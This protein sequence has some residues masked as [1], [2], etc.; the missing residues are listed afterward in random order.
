MSINSSDFS[1]QGVTY[2]LHSEP[3]SKDELIALRE[4]NAKAIQNTADS[5]KTSQDTSN[6]KTFSTSVKVEESDIESINEKMSQL[7]VQLNFEM[8]EDRDRNII[9]VLDQ[10]TGDVVRQIPTEDFLRM[11]ERIEAIMS[12]LQEVEGDLSN[13][14]VKGAFVNSEV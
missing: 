5:N 4:A 2:S 10:A 8:T 3:R 1:K 14:E 9:K 13:A 7:N 12:E 11:S 6:S